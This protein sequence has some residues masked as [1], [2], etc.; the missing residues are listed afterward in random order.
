MKISSGN[1]GKFTE[2]GK[3]LC[4]ACRSGEAINSILCQFCISVGCIRDIVLLEV[5]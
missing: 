2:E 3:F 5:T 1:T 4:I